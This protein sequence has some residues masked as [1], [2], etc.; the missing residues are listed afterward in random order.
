MKDRMIRIPTRLNTGLR[1]TKLNSCNQ[2]HL[3]IKSDIYSFVMEMIH[4]SHKQIRLQLFDF[5]KDMRKHKSIN[6]SRIDL[7]NQLLISKKTRI[8]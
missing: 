4:W 1:G 7:F 6:M 2:I 3:L 5:N 8:D